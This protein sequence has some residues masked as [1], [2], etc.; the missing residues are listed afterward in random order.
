MHVSGFP[1]LVGVPAVPGI[2]A[3]VNIPFDKGFSTYF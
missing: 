2:P 3:V 1:A